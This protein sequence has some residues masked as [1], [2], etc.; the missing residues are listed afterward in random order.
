MPKHPSLK[1]MDYEAC[2]G[3]KDLYRALEA[4]VSKQGRG[5]II[6]RPGSMYMDSFYKLEVLTTRYLLTLQDYSTVNAIVVDPHKAITSSGQDISI[7]SEVQFSVGTIVSVKAHP[8]QP[9]IRIRR[10][11]DW[12]THCKDSIGY[13]IGFGTS[14]RSSCR[15][16]NK[17]FDKDDLR[18]KT[19]L[20]IGGSHPTVAEISFCL[21]QSCIQKGSKHYNPKVQ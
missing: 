7:S 3:K 14:S 20:Q 13:Y 18:V 21:S 19:R 5:V 10:D 8:H 4:I 9:T 6:H 17:V 2:K 1:I 16:C 11:L 15:G 12:P